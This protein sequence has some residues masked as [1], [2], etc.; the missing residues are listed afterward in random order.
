MTVLKN[1]AE[2][3]VSD[4]E[5]ALQEAGKKKIKEV[6]ELKKTNNEL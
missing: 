2:K 6:D 3:K 1:T 4:L 5:K